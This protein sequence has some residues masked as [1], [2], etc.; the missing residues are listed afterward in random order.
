[1]PKEQKVQVSDTTMTPR[2]TKAGYQK[3]NEEKGL[4]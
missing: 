3:I 4:S 2:K 1:V